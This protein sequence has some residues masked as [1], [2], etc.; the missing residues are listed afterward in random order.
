MS[1]TAIDKGKAPASSALPHRSLPQ[2]PSLA[3]SPTIP[4]DQVCLSLLLQIFYESRSVIRYV[5]LPITVYFFMCPA[6]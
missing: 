4:T 3:V 5:L 2:P 1:S 6:D